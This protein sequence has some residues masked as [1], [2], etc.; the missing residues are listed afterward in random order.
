MGMGRNDR[1]RKRTKALMA[2]TGIGRTL[3][4]PAKEMHVKNKGLF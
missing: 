2:K 1:H 4:A 3:R